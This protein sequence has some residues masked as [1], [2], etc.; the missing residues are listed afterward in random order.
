MGSMI[1]GRVA[2]G[3]DPSGGSWMFP[4]F[5]LRGDNHRPIIAGRSSIVMTG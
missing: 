1:D 4:R 2:I 5:T 3:R